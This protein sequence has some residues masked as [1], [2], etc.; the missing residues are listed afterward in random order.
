[1]D[2]KPDFREDRKYA[3]TE[4]QRVE[5]YEQQL[6]PL[7][8]K[9][10]QIMIYDSEMAQELLN[11][12]NSITKHAEILG[13]EIFAKIVQ[14][15]TKIEEYQKNEGKAKESHEQTK[16]ILADIKRVLSEKEKM[17]RETLLEEFG[18][19]SSEYKTKAEGFQY[20]DRETIEPQITSL[21]AETLMRSIREGEKP[22]L[23]EVLSKKEATSLQIYINEKIYQFIQS[24]NPIMK[25]AGNELKY[26]VADRN[27][28]VYDLTTWR[29]I[30]DAQ[31]GRDRKDELEPDSFIQSSTNDIS[32]VPYNE[33]TSI[34]SRLLQ[35][36]L[37]VQNLEMNLTRV[38]QIG[39]Q[40]LK[41]KD[42][43]KMDLEWLS[44]QIS[45]DYLKQ[46]EQER[47]QVEGKKTKSPYIPDKREPLYDFF[48]EE[49]IRKRDPL[50]YYFSNHENEDLGPNVHKKK[51]WEMTY[52]NQQGIKM[53]IHE[54]E[55]GGRGEIDSKITLKGDGGSSTEGYIYGARLIY[56]NHDIITYARLIDKMT[57]GNLYQ[58][59]L[60]ELGTFM[61]LLVIQ[62]SP[63]PIDWKMRRVLNKLPIFT[64]LRESY[65][66]VAE[67]TKITKV[68]F[69][70]EEKNRR[71]YFYTTSGFKDRIRNDSHELKSQENFS[72][73]T[74]LKDK[75]PAEET[76]EQD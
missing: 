5:L 10:S 61:E 38:V 49:E 74:A 26:N 71:D 29:I 12:Y 39:D 30:D 64:N 58:S 54:I 3:L 40:V 23:I 34:F 56:D 60:N 4:N 57:N 7:K 43:A 69:R 65:E 37:K 15:E 72:N 53:Q 41:V 35:R 18:R 13:L 75:V 52:F 59:L 68:A 62:G 36:K 45:E 8:A 32:L 48:E 22:V 1:M 55:A 20:A 46:K 44:S 14:L 47:L 33:K 19:I 6:L 63:Q 11:E 73:E 31:L 70:N 2:I 51:G 16:L 67:Q 17:D 66:R 21:H 42:L 9:I 24:N 50:N 27:D 28:A 25:K 76:L